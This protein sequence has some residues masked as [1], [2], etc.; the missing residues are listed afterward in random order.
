MVRSGLGV[1]V[2]AS[3]MTLLI[4]ASKEN[5]QGRKLECTPIACCTGDDN[6]RIYGCMWKDGPQR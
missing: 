3:I 2:G 5:A 6:G 1:L 4:L